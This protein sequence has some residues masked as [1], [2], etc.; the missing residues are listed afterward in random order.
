MIVSAITLIL[1]GGLVVRARSGS[2]GDEL[3]SEIE[4]LSG[5]VEL[6]AAQSDALEEQ[7]RLLA[8]ESVA[9][10][11]DRPDD[12][13]TNVAASK[14]HRYLAAYEIEAAELAEA[15][16]EAAVSIDRDRPEAYEELGEIELLL[17]DDFS[18]AEWFTRAYERADQEGEMRGRLSSRVGVL[19]SRALSVESALMLFEQAGGMGY[20]PREDVRTGI[21]LA[22]ALVSSY[23]ALEDDLLDQAIIF[24]DFVWAEN[25]A[26]EPLSL[27]RQNLYDAV[28]KDN[29]VRALEGVIGHLSAEDEETEPYGEN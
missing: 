9:F 17:G 5:E 22:E 28:G 4:A 29:V 26:N 19:D 10:A 16:A 2:S 21:A 27:A 25:P 12:Y 8:D 24:V 6:Q 11:V 15:Y 23:T 14:I 1:I 3:I 7:V 18:A 20:D 13:D